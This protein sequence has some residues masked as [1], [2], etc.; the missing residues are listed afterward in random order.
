MCKTSKW[1]NIII[2][3]RMM[4]WKRKQVSGRIRQLLTSNL[5]MKD[6]YE[7]VLLEEYIGTIALI[8]YTYVM[9]VIVIVG[10]SLW[11]DGFKWTRNSIIHRRYYVSM[12]SVQQINDVM[13]HIL[14]FW[15]IT[16]QKTVTLNLIIHVMCA[17]IGCT[18]SNVL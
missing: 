8:L 1:N 6:M 7:H 4:E 17:L 5:W 10:S 16:M 18:T 13:I 12:S 2:H 14:L 15:E 9:G 3:P 11:I